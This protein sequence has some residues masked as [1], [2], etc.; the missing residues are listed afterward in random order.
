M[1]QIADKTFLKWS[2][3]QDA[4][5]KILY[6]GDR[7]LIGAE[8]EFVN[9]FL[10]HHPK[11]EF[12]SE[13]MIRIEIKTQKNHPRSKPY[14][15]FFI[16]K[17]DCLED[18]SYLKCRSD[19]NKAVN[20]FD[21]Y[22][23]VYRCEIEDQIIY[24]LNCGVRQCE[25]CNSIDNIQ[26]DHVKDFVT[27]VNEFEKLYQLNK[28]I[29]DCKS[30]D[31]LAGFKLFVDRK[32]ALKWQNYHHENATYQKLCGKCNRQKKKAGRYRQLNN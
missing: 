8:F 2:D 22:L 28:T 31:N 15:G 30:D 4:I 5:K 21:N 17:K 23:K 7:T 6:A 25:L 1:Y 20:I 13:G 9:E 16:I 18:I 12:K 10:K 24:Q 3:V 29:L 14:P 26:I 32:F 11:Y 19:K 27:L